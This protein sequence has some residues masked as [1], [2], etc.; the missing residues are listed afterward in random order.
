MASDFSRG[1]IIVLVILLIGVVAAYVS[2]QPTTSMYATDEVSAKDF[3]L[4][5][6][7]A[8]YPDAKLKAVNVNKLNDSGMWNVDVKITT[9][10][11]GS[12]CPDVKIRHYSLLP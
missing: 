2:T 1:V 6:A 11:Y 3:A 7:K 9:N 8:A 4:N 5:D 10:A 12:C